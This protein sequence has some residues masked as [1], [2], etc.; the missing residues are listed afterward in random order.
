MR[1]YH[2]KR[3]VLLRL[4]KDIKLDDLAKLINIIISLSNAYAIVNRTSSIWLNIILEVSGKLLKKSGI[5]NKELIKVYGA[6]DEVI[7]ICAKLKKN[8]GKVVF[9]DIASMPT[10]MLS[11][12]FKWR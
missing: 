6:M 5:I 2:T 1:S 3:E 7:Y 9:E 11:H 8:I 12:T 10:E 4:V